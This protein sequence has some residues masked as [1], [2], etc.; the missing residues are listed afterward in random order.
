MADN[1]Q[2]LPDAIA[3]SRHAFTNIS[4]NIAMSLTVIIA[5]AGWIN[6][7]TGLLLNEAAALLVIANGLH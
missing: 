6:L 1:L 3:L 2:R 4:Q 5:L 7:V